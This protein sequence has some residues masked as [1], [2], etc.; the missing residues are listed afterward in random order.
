MMGAM[1]NKR[2]DYGSGLMKG[3]PENGGGRDA[4]TIVVAIDDDGLAGIDSLADS[5]IGFIE[6]RLIKI[7]KLSKSSPKRWFWWIQKI[8]L[9]RSGFETALVKKGF[10]NMLRLVGW[11]V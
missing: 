6:L 11:W 10:E 1:G 9:L 7:G 5:S 2:L 8:F 3:S 4:V